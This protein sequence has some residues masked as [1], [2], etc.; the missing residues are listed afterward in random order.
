MLLRDCE[1]D[2][3]AHLGIGHALCLA[4]I[5]KVPRTVAKREGHFAWCAELSINFI[6][7][8][9]LP[10]SYHKIE[11]WFSHFKHIVIYKY[12]FWKSAFHIRPHMFN[13]KLIPSSCFITE[14]HQNCTHILMVHLATYRYNLTRVTRFWKTPGI[15]QKSIQMGGQS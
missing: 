13:L 11:V 14:R 6:A 7:S 5:L 10:F 2:S 12:N 1:S 4:H 8:P 15:R 9:A 3:A